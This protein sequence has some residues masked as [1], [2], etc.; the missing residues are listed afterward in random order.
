MLKTHVRPSRDLRNNYS[1]LAGIV[2]DH[3]HVIITNNGKGESVLIGIDEYAEY[4]KYMHRRYVNEELA[5]AKAQSNNP[6]TQWKS[7]DDVWGKIRAKYEL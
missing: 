5:K 6:D 3:N 7:H 1:E 4:E 2:K